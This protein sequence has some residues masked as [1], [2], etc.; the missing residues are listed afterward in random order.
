MGKGGQD[1]LRSASEAERQR[2]CALKA[3]AVSANAKVQLLLRKVQLF[4]RNVQY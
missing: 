2:S 3:C 1:A 4:L